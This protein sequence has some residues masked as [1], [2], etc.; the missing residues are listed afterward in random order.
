MEEDHLPELELYTRAHR[1][2]LAASRKMG[3]FSCTT[4]VTESQHVCARQISTGAQSV[5]PHIM[6]IARMGLARL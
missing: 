4:K 2:L 5:V 3:A 6:C 1:L